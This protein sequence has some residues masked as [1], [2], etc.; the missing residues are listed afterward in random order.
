MGIATDSAADA[1]RPQHFIAGDGLRAYGALGIVL[2]HLG[3]G[4]ARRYGDFSLDLDDSYGDVPGGLII[5][6]QAAVPVFFALSGYLVGGPFIRAWIEG[7]PMPRVGKYAERR[8]RR[9]APA[10]WLVLAYLLI[11]HGAA[12]ASSGQ[13][14][15]MFGFQHTMYGQSF[16]FLQYV[17]QMW[18]IDVEMYF[19]LVVPLLAVALFAMATRVL[20][21][22]TE[23]ARRRVAGAGLVLTGLASL[24]LAYHHYAGSAAG[25]SI[26]VWWAAFVPGIFLAAVEVP[27]RERLPGTALG[28]NLAWVVLALAVAGFL[29]FSQADVLNPHRSRTSEL[30][31][32]SGFVAAALIWQ[33]STGS[34]WR[35][36]ANRPIEAI[37][38]WSF[39]IFVWHV[40]V[41]QELFRHI[42]AHAHSPK[43]Q[44]LILIVPAWAISIALGA[45][46][47][48]FVEQPLIKRSAKPVPAEAAVLGQA[49]AGAGAARP[50]M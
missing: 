45:L 11:R 36:L 32:G 28:R 1:R 37:G 47:W 49:G 6:M 29:L 39:G 14:A 16:P 41:V 46:T 23:A 25:N 34:A 10:F 20:P 13:I 9:I 7:R 5:A 43:A 40:A 48:R 42:D 27:A 17:P 50:R 30:V 15:A 8:V 22:G 38:R 19:Y 3:I 26:L 24:L 4:A 18:T 12:G 44:L 33:W 21:S 31:A 2:F 35:V